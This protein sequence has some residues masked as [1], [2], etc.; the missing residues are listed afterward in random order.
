MCSLVAR[1]FKPT[2]AKGRPPVF[3][4]VPLLESKDVLCRRVATGARVW[5]DGRWQR[6]EF[7]IVDTRQ[8]DLNGKLVVLN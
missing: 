8:A 5:R 7:M 3:A 4:V 2:G 6:K 1:G